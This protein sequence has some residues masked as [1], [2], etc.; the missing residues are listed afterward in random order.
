MTS[1]QT[2]TFYDNLAEAYRYIFPDWLGSV[3][4]QGEELD[5]FLEALGFLPANHTL[6]DCTCG[7]GTQTFG[8]ASRGW[9][10]HATDLSPKSVD[11]AREYSGEFDMIFAPTFGV[12]DLL[13]SPDSP[14]Q[15]D[16]VMA[17]D[18]AIPHL[19][20]D[21]DLITGLTTMRDH[22]ADNGLMMMS[23]RDYDALMENPPKSTLPSVHESEQGKRMI[24]QVWDWADDLSSYDLN[25]YV[26]THHG[27]EITTQS[28][29]SQ[30]RAL[31]RETLSLA[32]SQVGLT[33]IQWF[34]PVESGWYQP[35]VIARKR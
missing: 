10:V 24:F 30:Y 9:K 21:T 6:Y 28:F 35:I 33:D 19:M 8:L 15:Y 31:R 23:I 4:R 27:D 11:L 5:K 32:L 25:M 7:I 34:M 29:P 3:A 12:A 18:N 13:Q 17:M 1:K 14:T 2:E 26:V 16:V 20:T 22:T